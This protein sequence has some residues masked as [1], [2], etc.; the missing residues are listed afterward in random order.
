MTLYE[1]FEACQRRITDRMPCQW[2]CFGPDCEILAIT[3]DNTLVASAVVHNHP[4]LL[5][6]AVEIPGHAWF[7]DP[8]YRDAFIKEITDEN[9]SIASTELTSTQI[10]MMLAEVC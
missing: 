4:D 6:R 5:V 7:V 1:L 3:N 10:L 2:Q 9:L 8:D